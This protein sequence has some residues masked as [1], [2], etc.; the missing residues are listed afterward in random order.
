MMEETISLPQE[1]S[2]R[3]W[4]AGQVLAEVLR[5]YAVD[6]KCGIGTEH[7]VR[8]VPAHAY[9]LADAMLAERSKP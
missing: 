5:M 9:K 4:F 8:N 3:D 2:L 6:N 1:I 7:L